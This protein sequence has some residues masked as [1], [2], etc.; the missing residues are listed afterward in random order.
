MQGI[1]LFALC[2][3][4]ACAFPAVSA[5]AAEI[6]VPGDCKTIQKAIDKAQ[7]GDTVRVDKGTWKE[8]VTLKPGVALLGSGAAATK[9]KAPESG[10][11]VLTIPDSDWTWVDGFAVE[12]DPEGR[13][14]DASKCR[15]TLSNCVIS[16]CKEGLALKDCFQTVIRNCLFW[17][18]QT[19]VRSLDSDFTLS[20]NKFEANADAKQGLLAHQSS[21]GSERN[22]FIGAEWGIHVTGS[23][24]ALIQSNVFFRNSEGG[25]NLESKAALKIR[26]NIFAESERGIYLYFGKAAVSC[27][28]MFNVK[29][30]YVLSGEESGNE[31]PFKPD[32]GT[33]ELAADPLFADISKGDFRLREKSSC[34]GTGDRRVVFN[35]GTPVDMGCY[36]AREKDD[37]GPSEDAKAREACRPDPDRLV[38]NNV[39]EEYA[40]IRRVRC[41]CGGSFKVEMQG[42]GEENGRPCD[43]LSAKCTSCGKARSFKFDISRFFPHD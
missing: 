22:A 33:G 18:N 37:I 5:H 17:N 29:A 16:G 32:P 4:V 39:G 3:A 2:A 30:P 14:V 1:R 20:A 26:N 10:G 13:G 38:A 23:G 35:P 21:F 8:F 42:L 19:G 40:Y 41:A 15:F 31:E 24:F 6:K 12:S 9:L 7:K 11:S 27:N 28:D 25:I 43:T 34:A 36:P